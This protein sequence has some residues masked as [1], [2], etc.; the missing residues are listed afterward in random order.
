M[1][2]VRHDVRC[3]SQRDST[4]DAPEPTR[5]LL[6]SGFI[7]G[8]FDWSARSQ[9]PIHHDYGDVAPPTVHPQR[10]NATLQRRWGGKNTCHIHGFPCV[11][12]SAKS[13]HVQTCWKNDSHV[14]PSN[15]KVTSVPCCGQ[16]HPTKPNY[17]CQAR[18]ADVFESECDSRAQ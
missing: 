6:K 16:L 18:G 15:L 13:G 8:V 1:I 14:T 12:C 3:A 9:W 17:I 4:H 10:S 2:E 7:Q 5:H 11:T